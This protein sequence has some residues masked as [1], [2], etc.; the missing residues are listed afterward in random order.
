MEKGARQGCPLSSRLFKLLVADMNEKLEKEIWGGIK[1]RGR[2]I[3]LL[4]YADDV[5]LIAENE[6][7]M[8][9]MIRVMEKYI[10]GKGLQ[11]NV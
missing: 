6:G 2:K 10:E 3:S 7:A 11:V 9:G 1:V 4:A 8:N 5:T